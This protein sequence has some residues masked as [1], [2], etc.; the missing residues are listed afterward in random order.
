[1]SLRVKCRGRSEERKRLEAVCEDAIPPLR[2]DRNSRR[3]R[4]H[5]LVTPQR[6]TVYAT[7][8]LQVLTRV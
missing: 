1:M 2:K 7:V 6:G 3:G 5:A 4:G 8:W